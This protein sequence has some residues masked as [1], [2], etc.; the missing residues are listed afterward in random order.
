MFDDIFGELDADRIT[1]M[2]GSLSEI[3][4]VF[5]TTTS[6]RFFGK[7]EHWKHESHFY[8]ITEGTVTA[9]DLA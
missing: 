1:N 8:E 4:Q 7:V 6:P 2:I 9:R 3:G 5:I